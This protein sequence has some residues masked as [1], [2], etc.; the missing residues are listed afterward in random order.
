VIGIERSV[1]VSMWC[2]IK[3]HWWLLVIGAVFLL[4]GY[5]AVQGFLERTRGPLDSLNYTLANVRATELSVGILAHAVFDGLAG[6]LVS[7][8]LF[9]WFKVR[10]LEDKVK[11]LQ[12]GGTTPQRAR[13]VT[14][15]PVAGLASPEGGDVRISRLALISL[16]LSCSGAIPIPGLLGTL[17][18]IVCAH[19]ARK[20]IRKD[21]RL[22]GERIVLAAV[23]V[24]YAT[25]ML[26]IVLGI[27]AVI[28]IRHPSA[29]QWLFRL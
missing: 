20:E 4:Q 25:L 9:F 14:A 17:A 24:G 29:L 28:H 12:D 13:G 5:F 23:V 22:R 15:Q 6:A 26:N 7:F 21:R 10:D 18:G 11:R 1:N 16:V 2:K 19:R 8:L 27:A 3:G